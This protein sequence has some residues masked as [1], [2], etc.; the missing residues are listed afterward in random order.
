M[1]R[2]LLGRTTQTWASSHYGRSFICATNHRASYSPNRVTQENWERALDWGATH[3]ALRIYNRYT[4]NVRVCVRSEVA[5]CTTNGIKGATPRA[6]KQACGAHPIFSQL[7]WRVRGA[8]ASKP[9]RALL[10]AFH[11]L[12]QHMCGKRGAK[13][14]AQWSAEGLRTQKSVSVTNPYVTSGSGVH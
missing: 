14:G 4:T 9:A 6:A 3:R 10:H 7:L 2:R 13:R 5:A 11:L 8:Y 12:R 1:Y